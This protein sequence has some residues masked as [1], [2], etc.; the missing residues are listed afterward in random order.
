MPFSVGEH[1]QFEHKLTER[2]RKRTNSRLF[3]IPS[4][5]NRTPQKNN[6]IVYE[7]KI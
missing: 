2:E 7:N 1:I 6:V 4:K 5:W 3:F